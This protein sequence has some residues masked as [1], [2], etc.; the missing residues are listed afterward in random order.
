MISKKYNYP[1]VQHMRHFQQF[2]YS[3]LRI[4]L[5]NCSQYYKIYDLDYKYYNQYKEI[6]RSGEI[7][8]WKKKYNDGGCGADVLMEK[9]L[10]R[11]AYINNVRTK[12]AILVKQGNL[13]W[14]ESDNQIIAEEKRKF[15]ELGCEKKIEESRQMSVKSIASKYS[16][17]DKQRIEAESK[18]QIKVRIF[19]G[20]SILLIGLTTLILNKK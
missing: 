14:V 18:Y 1:I 9:C 2:Q 16:D 3:L 19:M 4:S 15:T 17:L 13:N 7:A 10:E 11:E 8:K 20:A 6:T 12:S 5:R